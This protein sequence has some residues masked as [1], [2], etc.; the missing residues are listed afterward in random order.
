MALQLMLN[1]LYKFTTSLF[2][3]H[4]SAGRGQV[5]ARM[6]WQVQACGN[7][8][9]LFIMRLFASAANSASLDL[10]W[11]LMALAYETFILGLHGFL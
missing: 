9:L 3:K 2:I 4:G 1:C 8:L 7:L 5:Q 10:R 11:H 6:I